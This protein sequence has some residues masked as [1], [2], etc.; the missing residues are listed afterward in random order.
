MTETV[1]NLNLDPIQRVLIRSPNWLGDTVMFTPALAAIRR[2]FPHWHLTLLAKAASASLLEECPHIDEVV[3]Y[4][5]PG[6]HAGWSGRLKLAQHLRS[7]KYDLVLLFQNA[8]GAAVISRLAGIPI[9]VGY[10][11]DGRGG[12]LTHR[13]ARPSNGKR[14]PLITYF[15]GLLQALGISSETSPPMLHTSK[16]E[17]THAIAMLGSYGVGSADLLIGLNPGS[18]YGTAKQWS[19]RQYAAVADHLARITGGTIVIVG[20]PGEQGLGARI[21]ERMK[22]SPIV[23]SGKTTVRELMGIL[24]QC[25][26]LVTND[27]GPM[28]VA[29]ALGVPVIA[30]FGPT[31]PTATA[32]VGPQ[33]QLVA[34]QIG[35]SPCLLRACPLDHGCMNGISEQEVFD[36]AMKVLA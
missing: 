11:T 34:T 14:Q 21:A 20:G 9:R 30:I 22:V 27:T 6:I 35:C 3:V 2:V 24:K 32:P 15:L 31:D 18:V 23:M 10:D 7:G 28:H 29:S 16:A 36:A 26:I 12:L 25:R 17:E 8:I 33:H 19:F 4:E 13:I 5:A 1:V